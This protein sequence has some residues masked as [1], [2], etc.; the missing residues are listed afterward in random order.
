M[1]HGL[2]RLADVVTLFVDI[3]RDDHKHQTT[4]LPHLS[5]LAMLNVCQD[6]LKHTQNSDKSD[7]VKSKLG[8]VL[9]LLVRRLVDRPDPVVVQQSAHTAEDDAQALPALPLL[10][11]KHIT[12]A[13]HFQQSSFHHAK[14]SVFL[15][16][17]QFVFGL[18][19]LKEE[20]VTV[21]N[22]LLVVVVVFLRI[23][24]RWMKSHRVGFVTSHQL[25]N[26]PLPSSIANMWPLPVA[27]SCT[28]TLPKP[29]RDCACVIQSSHRSRSSRIHL[30]CLGAVISSPSR[31]YPRR[32]IFAD[33]VAIRAISAIWQCLFFFLFFF[34]R[35]IVMIRV[36]VRVMFDYLVFNLH[37]SLLADHY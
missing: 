25:Y 3:L 10:E 6:I 14:M 13:V 17:R 35:Q 22:V 24:I 20:I 4:L 31:S 26:T 28:C 21:V 33:C 37:F 5:T 7:D 27:S 12:R 32:L 11:S 23:D 19:P 9:V 2:H 36:R 15:W 29:G 16:C 30:P 34:F 1:A 8:E 18:H